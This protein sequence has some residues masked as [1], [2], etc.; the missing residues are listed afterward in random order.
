[1]L[2]ITTQQEEDALLWVKIVMPSSN[3]K[4]KLVDEWHSA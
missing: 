3:P 1:M 2:E 4:L